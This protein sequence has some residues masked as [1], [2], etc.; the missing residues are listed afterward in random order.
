MN[1]ERYLSFVVDEQSVEDKLKAH[2]P[3]R[4]VMRFKVAEKQGL[5]LEVL[6]RPTSGHLIL[7]YLR[8]L[9]R[10]RELGFILWPLVLSWVYWGQ[11]GIEP[12]GLF[13]FGAVVCIQLAAYHFQAVQSAWSGQ[14][15]YWKGS[16][17]GILEGELHPGF[18]RA[19]GWV[20]FL[21][22]SVMG[23]MVI[24]TDPSVYLPP[25]G[26][27]LLGF[28]FYL[29]PQLNKSVLILEIT[30]A[31]VYG[32]VLIW[33]LGLFFKA[34]REDLL[35][36]SL[37][38]F[39]WA[40]LVL[41]DGGL[42]HLKKMLALSR[43]RQSLVFLRFGG[44]DKVSLLFRILAALHIFLLSL[45]WVQSLKLSLIYIG[46]PLLALYIMGTKVKNIQ[47]P[48]SSRL[49]DLSRYSFLYALFL[50]G[51]LTFLVWREQFWTL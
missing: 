35:T 15:W 4:Q 24:S 34:S 21:L 47:S 51:L 11:M 50:G 27:G 28:L 16:T 42:K 8:F 26:I 32:P 22:S 39:S 45:F 1:A 33:G 6:K 23:V 7:S 20:L 40:F 43:A 29:L 41:M 49:R 14:D 19:A 38:G 46:L 9:I 48:L 37:F 12:L 13:A 25:V 36:W 3:C 30:R 5:I 44:F 17:H 10:C 31:V 18:V 2:W